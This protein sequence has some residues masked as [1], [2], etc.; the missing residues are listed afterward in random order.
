MASTVNVSVRVVWQIVGQNVRRFA[1]S[2]KGLINKVLDRGESS[3]L[4]CSD[5]LL[6]ASKMPKQGTYNARGASQRGLK[7]IFWPRHNAKDHWRGRFFEGGCPG[8]QKGWMPWY[9]E[10][11]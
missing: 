6:A 7:L 5:A 3:Q 2:Q 9:F 1:L 11:R 8:S 4:C 10:A